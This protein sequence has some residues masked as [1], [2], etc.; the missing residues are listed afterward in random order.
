[1]GTSVHV[2]VLLA[3]AALALSDTQVKEHYIDLVSATAVAAENP[4]PLSE[5]LTLQQPM[6]VTTHVK[7]PEPALRVLLPQ[8][9]RPIYAWGDSFVCEWV[10]E[11]RGDQPFRFPTLPTDDQIRRDM[12]GAT[13]AAVG[14]RFSDKQLDGEIVGMHGLYGANSV[15]DSLTIVAP[16][17]RV[18]IRAGGK[19][20]LMGVS[21]TVIPTAQREYQVRGTIQVAHSGR[22]ELVIHS[23]TSLTVSIGR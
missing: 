12:P 3:C 22:T 14:L 6:L 8:L 10:I 9:D 19:W 7:S 5:R 4:V 17:D 16:G 11:N 23:D 1:M 21:K 2:A 20:R 18:R 13:V 15:P